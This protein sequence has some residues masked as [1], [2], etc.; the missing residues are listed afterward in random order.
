[1]SLSVIAFLF[2]VVFWVVTV[3]TRRVGVGNCLRMFNFNFFYSRI[4]V[5]I[6]ILGVD[7]DQDEGGCGKLSSYV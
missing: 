6:C 1:M 3:I 5:C 4:C 2:V 7:D